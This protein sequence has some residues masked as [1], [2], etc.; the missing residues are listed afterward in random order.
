[1]RRTSRIALLLALAGGLPASAAFAG[2]FGGGGG[3]STGEGDFAVRA[4]L[5]NPRFAEPG[6]PYGYFRSYARGPAYAVPA[7]PP[8]RRYDRRAARPYPY[9]SRGW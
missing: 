5:Q 8:A 6:S 7:P 9:E 3:G 1:M 2:D 4:E